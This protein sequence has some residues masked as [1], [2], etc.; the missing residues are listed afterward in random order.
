MTRIARA[1]FLSAGFVAMLSLNSAGAGELISTKPLLKD[2]VASNPGNEIIMPVLGEFDDNGDDYADRL[3]FKFKVFGAGTTTKLL[4]TPQKKF[5]TPQS[6]CTNPQFNDWDWDLEF[7]GEDG[8]HTGMILSFFV[9]CHD[10]A[11]GFFKEDYGTFVYVADTTQAGS[12][13]GK[14]YGPEAVSADFVD[15]DNDGN[16]EVKIVLVTEG[17]TDEK[18][19]VI[20]LKKGS[21]AVE[22][23]KKYTILQTWD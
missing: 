2:A 15:W 19:R 14:S 21:G 18:L 10:N 8:S 1:S 5:V 12:A 20:F 6:P 3:T 9:E 16:N 11:D 17:D 23:D 4:T 13:W 22:S 7:F